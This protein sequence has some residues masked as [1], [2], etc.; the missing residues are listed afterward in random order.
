ML[1][2]GQG[3][4]GVGKIRALGLAG[5][6]PQGHT[7]SESPWEPGCRF[8][9]EGQTAKQ[10]SGN[11]SCCSHGHTDTAFQPFPYAKDLLRGFG[12]SLGTSNT[13][14]VSNSVLEYLWPGADLSKSQE[15]PFLLADADAGNS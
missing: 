7:P 2:G 4:G 13:L 6:C 14:K 5:W 15:Q 9:V 10:W 1:A 11:S 8:G 3:T 12:S